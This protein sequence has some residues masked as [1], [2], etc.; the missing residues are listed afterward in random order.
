MV[1]RFSI[2]LTQLTYFAECAK[3]LNMTVASQNLH[4]AQSAVS[5]AITNLERALGV[6][7]FIRQHS[8]GLILTPAG[9]SLLRDTHH[10]FGQLTDAIEGLR[11][12]QESIRGTI[13]IA[14]F[15]TL[16]PFLIPK[17]IARLQEEHPELVVEVIEGDYEEN[18]SALRGGRAE[19]AINYQLTNAEGVS[20]EVVG[21]ATAHVILP[22]DHPLA[23]N[24][25][26]TLAALAKE[27]FILLDLPGSRD[28]FLN[29]LFQAGVTPRLKYRSSN[30]ETVRSMVASGLGFS[31]LNQRPRTVE[32][33]TGRRTVTVEIT[34]RVPS[35]T[36]IVASLS[37]VKF[38]ARAH[39]VADTVREVLAEPFPE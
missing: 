10:L 29:V 35:L 32:T 22:A 12:E 11:E 2:T 16:A 18:L 34:D 15:Q 14:C 23:A 27:P 25:R 30:Y 31:I 8:K 37:Q 17:L 3:T 9:E 24:E 5:T 13:T 33:Y 7:L 38:S 26:I 6:S 21:E 1:Q 36:V 19:L 20:H 28:Y 4:V 39:V